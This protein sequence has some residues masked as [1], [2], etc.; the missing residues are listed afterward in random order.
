MI[1]GLHIDEAC[2]GKVKV[3]LCAHKFLIEQRNIE[4]VAVEACNIA[5]S[6]NLSQR[7][8]HLTE[9]WLISHIFVGDVVDGGSFCR[10]RHLGIY[11]AGFRLYLAVRH[12]FYNRDFDD[13]VAVYIRARCLEIEEYDRACEF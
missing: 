8:G 7:V 12:Q 11:T 3:N 13:S 9:G 6:H 4:P 1:D 5:A 2:F 10:D